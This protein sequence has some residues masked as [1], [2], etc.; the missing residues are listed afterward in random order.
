MLKKDT[1]S[2]LFLIAVLCALL[3]IF[4]TNW[5]VTGDG[6]C[7]FYNSAILY[8]WHFRSGLSEFYAPFLQLNQQLDPNFLTNMIQVPLLHFLSPS[9]A[10]RTFFA[11]YIVCF[12]FG[13]RRLIFAINPDNAFLSSIGVLFVW[14]QLLMN[15]Y[16]NNCWS[17][18]LWFWILAVWIELQ[19][20]TSW[21]K[22]IGLSLLFLLG[23]FAHPI[24][25]VL[26]IISIVVL[27]GGAFCFDETHRW[28]L[29]FLFNQSKKLLF[30]ALPSLLLF[31][32][33]FLRRTWTEEH[34]VL[35]RGNLL[36]ALFKLSPLI[37]LSKQER[38]LLFVVSLVILSL[39]TWAAIQMIRKKQAAKNNYIGLLFFVMFLIVMFPPKSI[40]GGL[41]IGIRL[42]MLP[43]LSLLFWLATIDFS[44]WVQR[45]IPII[46]ICLSIAL[47]YLRLPLMLFS[48]DY[49][50]EILT[51][52][53]SIEEKSTVLALNY[54]WS[55]VNP[56]GSKSGISHTALFSHVDC[57]LGAYKP[58]IIS[59][60]YEANYY[61]FPMIERKETNFYR[62]TEIDGKNF[63]H[64]PPRADIR[65]YKTRSGGHAID[66]V[67]MLC[68][69]EQKHQH[70][71]TTEIKTQL[72][73][74]YTLAYRSPGG[75]A[76]LYKLGK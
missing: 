23:Y 44:R 4:L 11:L 42:G 53:D 65:N 5:I 32:H 75:R 76:L 7:H 28:R 10:E 45:S 52:L 36:V 48:S 71:Y 22:L 15:G 62:H 31:G 39:A 33:F 1:E 55:G 47:L 69:D 58:L 24:G 9:V 25:F 8:D 19:N 18:A 46:S 40:G 12:S 56:D 64:R 54:D 72:D 2:I 59:D 20:A 68:Y 26:S 41:D 29:D 57:Y 67:L 6:P 66:Y 14:S 70:E 35:E 17:I 43:H 49:A 51:C 73:E 61:Y 63:D 74:M 16:I 50:D 60:N 34:S 38:H 3:P 13:F 21:S 30:T 37:C 27:I